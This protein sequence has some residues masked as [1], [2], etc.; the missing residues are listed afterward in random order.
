VVGFGVV[1]GGGVWGGGWGIEN[2]HL[3]AWSQLA[4]QVTMFVQ[5]PIDSLWCNQAKI[6]CLA[7]WNINMQKN[8]KSQTIARSLY[9]THKAIHWTTTHVVRYS[10]RNTQHADLHNTRDTLQS[11]KHATHRPAQ[12]T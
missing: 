12:H 1:G 4:N 6:T 2:A 7:P 8:F 5:L 10:P 9:I 3:C 11:Q